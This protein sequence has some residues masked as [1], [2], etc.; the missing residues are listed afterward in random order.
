MA[1]ARG[2]LAAHVWAAE[3]R[4]AAAGAGMQEE[5]YGTKLVAALAA[6]AE[7]LKSIEDKVQDVAKGVGS[8]QPK[9]PQR[10]DASS[11]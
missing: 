2:E 6:Q 3:V 1:G 7:S 4:S 5:T 8:L 9:A 11:Q 10:S